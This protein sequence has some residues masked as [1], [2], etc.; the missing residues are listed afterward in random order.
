MTP[1]P[2]GSSHHDATLRLFVSSKRQPAN[3]TTGFSPSKWQTQHQI[4]G[5]VILNYSLQQSSPLS[6]TESMSRKLIARKQ[7]RKYQ[8]EI[9]HFSFTTT[10]RSPLS[11]DR[12][13]QCNDQPQQ[14]KLSSVVPTRKIFE[15]NSDAEMGGNL[16]IKD[17]V[18]LVHREGAGQGGDLWSNLFLISTNNAVLI[19]CF[20]CR[21][22]PHSLKHLISSSTPSSTSSIPESDNG[23]ISYFW[24]LKRYQIPGISKLFY[25]PPQLSPSSSVPHSTSLRNR[26]FLITSFSEPSVGISPSP[27]ARHVRQESQITKNFNIYVLTLCPLESVIEEFLAKYFSNDISIVDGQGQ[28][29]QQQ[30]GRKDNLIDDEKRQQSLVWLLIHLTQIDSLQHSIS[31]SIFNDSREEDRD[32]LFVNK[33]MREIAK[34]NATQM[35][36]YYSTILAPVQSPSPPSHNHTLSD[37]VLNQHT[38]I[39]LI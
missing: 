3:S 20:A 17:I 23:R 4:C 14:Q 21:P 24:I 34:H 26:I 16:V 39:F 15:L 13:I 5:F 10:F 9:H 35:R 28:S 2:I 7:H 19:V 38:N 32:E 11:S 12:H 18:P 31:T 22:L 25:R 29:Q 37:M 36:K 33:V 1:P 8:A 27:A 6:G 30:S